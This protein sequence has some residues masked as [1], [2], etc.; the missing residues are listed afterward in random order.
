MMGVLPP[1]RQNEVLQ[2]H[3][4]LRAFQHQ[5]QRTCNKSKF[6]CRFE[7]KLGKNLKQSVTEWVTASKKKCWLEWQKQVEVLYFEKDVK[8]NSDGSYF[9]LLT[10]KPQN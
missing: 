3:L 2:T 1:L 5:G 7:Q 8:E 9:L 6:K 10:N 4:S